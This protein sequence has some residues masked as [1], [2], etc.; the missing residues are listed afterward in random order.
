MTTCCFERKI[1]NVAQNSIEN[2]LSTLKFYEF[3]IKLFYVL[4]MSSSKFPILEVPCE[5]DPRL[6]FILYS[7]LTLR[8]RSLTYIL[9]NFS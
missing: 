8:Y 3:A 7:D 6:E 2:F 9:H 5:K 4:V 1:T